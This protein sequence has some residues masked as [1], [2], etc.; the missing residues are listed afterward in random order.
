M[1]AN[2]IKD[3]LT[4]EE[5]AAIESGR[6]PD[7]ISDEEMGKMESSRLPQPSPLP[8]IGGIKSDLAKRGR[9]MMQNVEEMKQYGKGGGLNREI[10]GLEYGLRQTG[11]AFGGASDVVANLAAPVAKDI[12]KKVVKPTFQFTSGDEEFAR[13]GLRNVGEKWQQFSEKYPRAA[14]NIGAIGNIVGFIPSGIAGA[15]GLKLGEFAA[16]KGAKG[17]NLDKP[18]EK[19]ATRAQTRQV[20]IN[21]PE[22]NMGARPET[23]A[24][25]GV[26]GKKAEDALGQWQALENQIIENLNPR[27]A[28]RLDDP[29]NI[30]TTNDL[31]KHAYDVIK[32]SNASQ[33]EKLLQIAE[34]D[35]IIN[36]WDE[37]YQGGKIDIL[38]A[39][40]LKIEQGRQGNW[41]STT[42]GIMSNPKAP[43]ESKA[44]NAIY[45]ALKVNVENK[46]SEGIKELNKALSEIIPMKLAAEKRMM[47]DKRNNFTR[48]DDVVAV[49]TGLASLSHGNVLPL[50]F[51][52]GN[53]AV[54]S[55]LMARTAYKTAQEIRG[56]KIP[57]GIK[58]IQDAMALP[59]KSESINLNIPTHIRK[60]R[61]IEKPIPEP[62]G[63]DIPTYVRKGVNI[64]RGR[65]IPESKKS[66]LSLE[67]YENNLKKYIDY[68]KGIDYYYDKN[69]GAFFKGGPSDRQG[70]GI[71]GI[72]TPGDRPEFA[73]GGEANIIEGERPYEAFSRQQELKGRGESGSGGSGDKGKTSPDVEQRGSPEDASGTSPAPDITVVKYTPENKEWLKGLSQSDWESLFSK[74]S[75]V[76]ISKAPLEVQK[77]IIRIRNSNR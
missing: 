13:Q 11:E 23:N 33:D 59:L 14:K 68:F 52:G 26:I 1:A 31:R 54:K 74:N 77:E 66:P 44:H 65:P 71:G 46:G 9:T 69:K 8:E 72:E 73:L 61:D 16:L 15:V 56:E 51:A 19:F 17:L 21:S 29:R 39:H 60:G 55:P 24:K 20:K 41:K 76:D 30:T 47:V 28:G 63:L 57:P 36:R 70:R 50:A 10:A 40:K 58:E 38:E 25:Y 22:W 67:E 2:K 34:V 45:D 62:I 75:T 32:R 64:E 48:L 53:I 37:V 18:L 12:Y 6:T 27:I 5:M 3:F 4:D 42:A 35:N 49:T 7:F 43:L